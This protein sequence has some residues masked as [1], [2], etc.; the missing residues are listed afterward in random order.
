MTEGPEWSLVLRPPVLATRG[1]LWL[2]AD[3]LEIHLGVEED[4]R[5]AR[6][7]HPGI[8]VEDLDGLANRLTDRGITVIWDDNFPGHR[9]F[10]AFDV[11]GNR[12]EFLQSIQD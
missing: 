5:P 1:G 7:A 11:L 6:K 10:Y 4:F 2:R 12:L 3:R 8:L 9:R